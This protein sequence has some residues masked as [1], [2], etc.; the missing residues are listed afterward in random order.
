MYGKDTTHCDSSG[1]FSFTCIYCLTKFHFLNMYKMYYIPRDFL[2]PQP[3]NF[4][5][6]K[7]IQFYLYQHKLSQ[8]VPICFYF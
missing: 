6:I 8:Q 3:Y 5:A 2:H 7:K 1:R 4:R